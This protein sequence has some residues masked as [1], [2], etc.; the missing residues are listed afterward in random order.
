M[1]P[2]EIEIALSSSLEEK[3]VTDDDAKEPEI[4]LSSSIE[5]KRVTD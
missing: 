3:R 5:G 2:K 1:M 4:A